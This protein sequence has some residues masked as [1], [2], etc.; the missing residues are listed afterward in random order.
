MSEPGTNHIFDVSEADFEA[1]V[2]ERSHEVPVV[3]DFWAAWCGPC[4]TLGPALESAV[5]ARGGAVE[6]AKL[7]VDANQLLAA[8]FNIRGIPAVKAFRDGKVAA[9]FT[10]AVP[11]AAIDEFLDRLVPS[12]ADELANADD[13]ESL[14]KALELNPR[15]AEAARRLGR[16]L[17]ERG[18]IDEARGLLEPLTGD[19]VADGLLARAQLEAAAAVDGVSPE[20]LDTAFAAWDAGD[21]ASALERLQEAISNAHDAELRDLIRRVMVAI[22]TELGPDDPLARE[23]RRRLAMALN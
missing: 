11:P 5:E 6:L 14:R 16:M 23:H 21:R 19:F 9:E 13:E 7:D 10:G 15:H 18:E 3:V 17:L 8:G 4:R 20:A 12:P 1:R 22:F 2:I